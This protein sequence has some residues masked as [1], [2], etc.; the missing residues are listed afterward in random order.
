VHECVALRISCIWEV[1][2]CRTLWPLEA[3]LQCVWRASQHHWWLFLFHD[4][5]CPGTKSKSEH[6]NQQTLPSH[7]SSHWSVQWSPSILQAH[8]LH[9]PHSSRHRAKLMHQHPQ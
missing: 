5:H 8:H 9:P 1:L 7:W 6:S 2:Y 3:L 4:N